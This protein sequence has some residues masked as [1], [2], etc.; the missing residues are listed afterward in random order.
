MDQKRNKHKQG[1]VESGIWRARLDNS[2][3]EVRI[4]IATLYRHAFKRDGVREIRSVAQWL[5]RQSNLEFGEQG[6]VNTDSGPI[7]YIF[8][9]QGA[10]ACVSKAPSQ[11]EIR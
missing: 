10:Q 3:A 2:R 11:H 4:F 7:E 8:Y 9:R 6:E 5:S 1:W